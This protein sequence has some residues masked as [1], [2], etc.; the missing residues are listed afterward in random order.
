MADKAQHHMSL[1]TQ[2][3]QNALPSVLQTPVHSLDLEALGRLF[4]PHGP[5]PRPCNSLL[6]A[7]A[8]WL[9][10]GSSISFIKH[11]QGQPQGLEWTGE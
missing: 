5:Q 1:Y 7:A 8:L 11:L 6:S 4:R 9:A 10:R 3:K 2:A